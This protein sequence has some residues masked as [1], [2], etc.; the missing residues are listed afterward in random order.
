MENLPTDIQNGITNLNNAWK[1]Y[2][3]ADMTAFDKSIDSHQQRIIDA[4]RHLI[5]VLSSEVL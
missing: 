2:N 3:E 4:K 1:E 5:N